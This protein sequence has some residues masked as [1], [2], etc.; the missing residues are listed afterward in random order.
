MNSTKSVARPVDVS[1]SKH[2][3][4]IRSEPP[5]EELK[6]D[7]SAVRS[8]ALAS[9]GWGTS[10]ATHPPVVIE[11]ENLVYQLRTV[12]HKQALKAA[13]QFSNAV[14]ANILSIQKPSLRDEVRR[15]SQCLDNALKPGGVI[16]FSGCS[17]EALCQLASNHTLIEQFNKLFVLVRDGTKLPRSPSKA[18]PDIL[19]HHFMWPQI[20]KAT[21]EFVAAAEGSIAS[22]DKSSL[23]EEV[24]F[25][26]QCFEN[27]LENPKREVDFSR[28]SANALRHLSSDS[29]FLERF[30]MLFSLVRRDKILTEHATSSVDIERGAEDATLAEN[31]PQQ[32]A[33]PS[34]ASAVPVVGSPFQ[35]EDESPLWD[36]K[37]D[38]TLSSGMTRQEESD[39]L[40]FRMR[41]SVDAWRAKQEAPRSDAE[42]ISAL[43]LEKIASDDEISKSGEFDP[44]KW[45]A[46]L[47][48]REFEDGDAGKRLVVVL[49]RA[50]K[51]P[52][53]ELDLIAVD[54]NTVD[55][56]EDEF[57]EFAVWRSLQQPPL[58]HIILPC[59]YEDSLPEFL[60]EFTDLKV[61]YAPNFLD[62]ANIEKLQKLEKLIIGVGDNQSFAAVSDKSNATTIWMSQDDTDAHIK[63]QKFFDEF[64]SKYRDDTTP[65][66]SEVEAVTRQ[67]KNVVFW[68]E[69]K[70]DFSQCDSKALSK[71]LSA[72]TNKKIVKEFS[73]IILRPKTALAIILPPDLTKVPAWLADVPGLDTLDVKNMQPKN[74]DV[75]KIKSLKH[76]YIGVRSQTGIRI[77]KPRDCTIHWNKSL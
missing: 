41:R 16:D 62:E 40:V 67:L 15:A 65:T 1:V 3:E 6:T 8:D 56:I 64:E 54:W 60:N 48:S 30:N 37:P 19:S 42:A 76:L 4:E 13:Q 71:V 77:L 34:Q 50:L 35:S 52:D 24:E 74:V 2:H 29:F 49:E 18:I 73:N 36:P 25:A 68:Q 61:L 33:P 12:M 72:L 70:M 45:I 9:H 51:N 31:L 7:I 63:A 38:D 11:A 28:C 32:D 57:K 66:R 27:A 20:L 69:N 14:E 23:R 17:T 43:D 59:D 44:K 22:I 21:E 46:D 53:H 5:K 75:Q 26:V 10:E 47:R 58:T 39:L 55:E